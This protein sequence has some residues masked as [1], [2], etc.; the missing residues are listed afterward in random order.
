MFAAVRKWQ[1]LEVQHKAGVDRYESRVVGTE[2][3]AYPYAYF[4]RNDA[5][6]EW[7]GMSG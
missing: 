6:I 3:A 5:D 4:R 7:A 1:S 2:G